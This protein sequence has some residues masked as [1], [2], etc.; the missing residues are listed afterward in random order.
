MTH[1]FRGSGI[2]L[3]VAWIL[4]AGALC[5][6]ATPVSQPKLIDPS[7]ENASGDRP[8]QWK[9]SQHEGAAGT[10]AWTAEARTG[11]RAVVVEKTNSVGYLVLEAGPLAV[12]PTHE[13]LSAIFL[14]V[15][16]L[17][18]GSQLYFCNEDAGLRGQGLLPCH[19]APHFL[20]RPPEMPPGH[21]QRHWCRWS[22]SN[23]AVATRLRL[24]FVGGPMKVLLDDAEFGPA[25]PPT[26]HRG[27]GGTH[28]QPYEEAR[29]RAHLAQR[30][31]PPARVETIARRPLFVVGDRLESALV[32]QGAYGHPQN[33]R[34]G[35]FAAAG[36]HLHTCTVQMGPN[37][38]EKNVAWNFPGGCDF[39]SLEQDLLHA[40]AADRQACIILQVRCDLPR[41]W[42]LDHLDDV[43]TA[44]DGQKWFCLRRDAH[45]QGK[46]A[47]ANGDQVLSGS[48]GSPAYRRDMDRALTEL[49]RYVAGADVGRIVV[50]F[51]IGGGNDGQFFDWSVG[52]ELDHSPG[53]RR[54]FQ[55]WLREVYG[56][57][58]T[59]LRTAWG[60]PRV[61]FET[62]TICGEAERNGKEPFLAA[63]GPE[64]RAADSNRYASV[65]PVKLV[66]HFAQ[67]LKAAIGRP[68][69]SMC[70]S[71]DAIHD[72]GANIYALSELLSGPDRMDSATAVQEY[73]DWRQI[74]GT[75]GTNACWGSYRL[76]GSVQ[77][78]EIDYRTYR[79]YAGGRWGMEELG[80]TDTAAGFRAQ[81][82]RD[83]G[84][85]ATRGMGAWYYD[86]SGGWYDDPELWSVVEESKRI[87]EWAH[88]RDAPSPVAQMAV[89]V[90]EAAG[91][92]ASP[93][94]F[95]TLTAATNAQRRA[96]NLSGV[97]YDLYLLD[98][99]THPQ[100][101][102]YKAYVFLTAFT[103]NRQ[104]VEAIQRRCGPGN[105]VVLPAPA[106]TASPDFP[107]AAA[108]MRRLTA[109]AG[110][111]IAGPLTP[112]LLHAIAC[113]AGIDTLG[114]PGQVIY[115]GSGVTLCH[116]V[117]CGP[118]EV[119]FGQPVD[120]IDLDGRTILAQGVRHWEFRGPWGE[121][122]IVFYR[123]SAVH[124]AARER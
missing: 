120:I 107:D 112:Q 110:V 1:S 13:Y 11:R 118:A 42:G 77:I 41:Q 80:A 31:P 97:P 39:R 104:Q 102:G 40:I 17:E 91:W 67:T 46:T 103:L 35:G 57:D 58:V 2:W 117:R 20:W 14:R 26:V 99:I 8:V 71:P 24:I 28:E 84:A 49:G 61:T 50:G 123:P 116:H 113:E 47:A 66:K 115:T 95:G 81:I 15:V 63:I 19:Y 54:G 64:R 106:G 68:V 60:D 69:F 96:L 119:Q 100:L 37:T 25:P 27:Q 7:F 36:I 45:P 23:E 4:A 43:W 85:A 59:S 44:E 124:A 38:G 29:A 53:H 86:M 10:I 3:S 90:D 108:L 5:R 111:R 18:F 48:Y 101:P 56:H 22:T 65:A 98:D 93:R 78:C 72:Q 75:G 105:V 114:T 109:L 74:G 6:G 73:S 94:S 70:Y 87:M 89:F 51:V 76:R 92:R 121:T 88:R 62:A 83:I 21:W 9:L 32:H 55:E 30:T 52:H 82:R 12:E 34:Y 33:S 16:Q 122:D 79:S